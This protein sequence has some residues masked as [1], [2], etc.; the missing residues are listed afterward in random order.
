MKRLL[1]GRRIALAGA[2]ALL[3]WA[4]GTSAQVGE[5]QLMAA[6]VYN[7]AAYTT[8]PDESRPDLTICVHRK[9]RS[10]LQD[11]LRNID[12]KPVRQHKVRVVSF[13][14]V[15]GP[16]DCAILVLGVD[17]LQADPALRAAVAG[18]NVLTICDCQDNRKGGEMIRLFNDGKAL[19]FAVDR[20]AVK[21]GS[22]SISSKLLR[23]ARDG[24]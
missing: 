19:A 20:A 5:S 6:F 14:A 10:E 9:V 11:A 2:L 22:L 16:R 7:F 13:G 1:I 23:L 21:A 15:R 4:A 24:P 8:W 17:G 18:Q 3:C 12:G